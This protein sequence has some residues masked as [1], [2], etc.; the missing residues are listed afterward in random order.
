M[1]A[2]GFKNLEYLRKNVVEM[3]ARPMESEDISK[4]FDEVYEYMDEAIRNGGKVLVHCAYGVSRSS[5]M[6]IAYLI[7]KHKLSYDAAYQIV[8][9][10]RDI[11]QPNEGFKIQLEE[12]ASKWI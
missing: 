4:H 7:R 5:S 12:Y 1:N 10:K 6:V 9:E 11:I 3:K 2:D 8:K